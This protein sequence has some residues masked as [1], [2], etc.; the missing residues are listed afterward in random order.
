MRASDPVKD[1]E[2]LDKHRANMQRTG[3]RLSRYE[4]EE[5]RRK[6]DLTALTRIEKLLDGE[7]L[8][9]TSCGK[10]IRKQD[11]T[12]IS[13]RAIE[14][15]YARLRPLLSAVEQTTLVEVESLDPV[16]LMRQVSS[17]IASN[18]QILLDICRQDEQARK[19]VYAVVDQLRNEFR[20]PIPAVEMPEHVTPQ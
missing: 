12:P 3:R 5:Q 4:T 9:C 16:E 14:L 6:R 2:K 7:V 20:Q 15:R 19:S 1:A 8:N 10:E 17:S 13:L 11:L 18:S